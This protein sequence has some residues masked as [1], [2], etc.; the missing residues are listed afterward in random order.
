MTFDSEIDRSQYATERRWQS[1]PKWFRILCWAI[2]GLFVLHLVLAVRISIGLIEADEI[3]TLRRHGA[4]I[5]YPWD[6]LEI[7]PIRPPRW[8]IPTYMK[9]RTYY[10]WLAAG[11]WGRSVNN[12]IGIVMERGSDNDLK[13]IGK[14]FH[15]IK[16]LRFNKSDF[17]NESLREINSCQRIELLDLSHND[18]DDQGVKMLENLR[19]LKELSLAE[20]LISDASID[21]LQKLPA[22]EKVFLY[23]TDVSAQAIHRWRAESRPALKISGGNDENP[24]ELG[25]TVRW[26]DGRRSAVFA[27]P[28]LLV[29][30]GP[31]ESPE[32]ERSE[33]SWT[34][35]GRTNLTWTSSPQASEGSSFCGTYRYTLKL[36]EFESECVTIHFENG[37]P[38]VDR[39]EM[40]MPVTK[41]QALKSVTFVERN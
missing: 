29:T 2:L 25:G 35:F 9:V 16:Y 26:S 14:H 18:L 39:F 34:E 21:T 22:L 20:T 33:T 31:L 41:Q 3:R 19:S 11:L 37:I 10:R 36:G 7:S 5:T 27:G 13:L 28:Y 17:S 15:F 6:T 30:E 4:K 24:I 32:F 23:I 38:S 12:V 8:L 40:R 1:S